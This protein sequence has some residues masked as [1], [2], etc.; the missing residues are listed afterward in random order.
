VDHSVRVVG[1]RAAFA[2]AA[3]WRAA[4]E[5]V[6]V[7]LLIM[8]HVWWV[9]A[10]LKLAWLA[11][12]VLAVASHRRRRE[13]AATLGFRAANFGACMRRYGL[14]VL[15]LAALPLVFAAYFHTFRPVTP[16]RIARFVIYYCIWGLFQQ[17]ALNGFF[18]NRLCQSARQADARWV[19]P[20]AAA[21]FAAVHAPNWF[22][23]TVTF[24]LGYFCA[25]IYLRYRN[26]YFLG[27]AHGLIG[28][29]LYLSVPDAVSLHFFIGP[30]AL[31][32]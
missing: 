3:R 31:R 5:A 15:V 7:F 14:L 2:P 17:Y 28:T 18:V 16:P 8:V 13:T 21:L 20:V 19:P 4:A 6:G 1:E 32:Y 23:V 29:A 30:R 25:T 22:L 10:Y 9:Q 26:L 11:I 24:A 12:L 27:L